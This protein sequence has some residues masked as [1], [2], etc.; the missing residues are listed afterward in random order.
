MSSESEP[1]WTWVRSGPGGV[2]GAQ[3]QPTFL[4]QEKELRTAVH[5]RIHH[6]ALIYEES[7]ARGEIMTEQCCIWNDVLW[8]MR[9]SAWSYVKFLERAEVCSSQHCSGYPSKI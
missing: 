5:L 9:V 4:L 1:Y 6:H 8:D 3:L 7:A 2:V